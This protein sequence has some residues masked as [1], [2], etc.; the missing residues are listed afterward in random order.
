LGDLHLKWEDI[1]EGAK[2]NLEIQLENSCKEFDMV[3][4][5]YL[6]RG[7]VF[8][9]YEWNEKEEIRK[10]ILQSFSR[11]FRTGKEEWSGN[12]FATCV[13][14]LG[15]SGMKWNELPRDVQETIYKGIGEPT[16]SFRSLSVLL[17]G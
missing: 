8:M 7:T 1:P 4:L 5:A 16:N 15:N 6:L 13:F 17:V 3:S 10:A 2:K 14:N 9:K 12:H 11:T